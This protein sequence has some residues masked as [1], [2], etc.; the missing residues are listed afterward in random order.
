MSDRDKTK[1][2]LIDELKALRKH[3]AKIERSKTE[4]RKSEQELRMMGHAVASSISGVGIADMEGKLIY[5]NDTLLKMWRYKHK[6]EMLGRHVT[7][8]WAGEGVQE[9]IKALYEKGG[10]I[11]EDIGKRKDGSLFDVQLVSS[12]IKDKSGRPQYMYGSFIDISD[13]K[14]TEKQILM[15]NE[16]LKFLL[17]STSV[18]FYTA[19]AGSEYKSIF[20]SENITQL[21][22]Y[23]ARSFIQESS[24][25]LDHIHPDDV[26]SV[27]D[28][29]ADV[30]DNDIHKEEY[31]F[32]KKNGSYIWLID[33][34]RLVRDKKGRP[35]EIIG[36]WLDISKNKEAE[37]DLQKAYELMEQR[38]EDRT[39]ELREANIQMRQ[40]I[41]ERIRFEKALKEREKELEKQT[42]ALEQKNITLREVIAQIEVEKRKI[43]DDIM[44]N[45]HVTITP[46]LEKLRLENVAPRQVALLHHHINDLTSSF[47]SEITKKS[48]KLTTKEIEVCNMVKAG[49]SNKDISRLQ[50]ISHKTVEGH[51]KSIRQKLGLTGKKINLT[52]YLQRL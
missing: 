17:S 32:Q 6:D 8:F 11:G 43:K 19:E 37:G 20:I 51:R 29:M 23:K 22:G 46:I 12:V 30:F 39:A 50:N 27:L 34:M 36:Y 33:E 14:E 52:S 48:M 25:W 4:L 18:V 28:G 49:L 26:Q 35:L 45:V 1:S 44:A 24:F 42:V 3:I 40:E 21:T 38:V 41:D 31:R 2:Q 7:E 13:R 16:R 10:R 5:V 47:G 9:T 15:A